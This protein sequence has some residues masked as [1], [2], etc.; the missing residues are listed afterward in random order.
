MYL[1]K[2]FSTVARVGHDAAV[3]NHVYDDPDDMLFK[4]FHYRHLGSLAY[5]SN[6]AVFDL[7]GYSFAGGLIAMCESLAKGSFSAS[8]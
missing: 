5:I 3:E 7:G 6:S 2:K 8:R 1:G 4:P